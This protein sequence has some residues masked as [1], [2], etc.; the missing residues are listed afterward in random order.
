MNDAFRVVGFYG[1]LCLGVVSISVEEHAV[2]HV[3]GG[4][5]G[6]GTFII[7]HMNQIGSK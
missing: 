4:S 6:R 7:Y 1:I 5:L 2:G 3:Q